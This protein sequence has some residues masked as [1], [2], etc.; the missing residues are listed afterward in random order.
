MPRVRSDRFGS[1]QALSFD[2]PRWKGIHVGGKRT[3]DPIA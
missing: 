1:E 3:D 2:F